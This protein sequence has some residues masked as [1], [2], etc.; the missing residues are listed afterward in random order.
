MNK[1]MPTA[2]ATVC[3]GLVLIAC[4]G[5]SGTSGERLESFTAEYLDHFWRDH[6]E[7]ATADGVH[8][9]DDRLS[10]SA[11]ADFEAEAADLRAFQTKLDAIPES[12]LGPEQKADRLWLAA[13]ME[14][15][16][17][18]LERER[19][20][21]RDPTKYI[22]FDGL[23]DLIQEDFAPAAERASNLLRRLGQ[24]PVMVSNARRNLG[25]PPRLFTETAI[26]TARAMAPFYATTVR[27]FAKA[28]PPLES[29]LNRAADEAAAAVADYAT[30]LEKE[31]LPR[32]DGDLAVG[33]QLYDF[34]LKRLHLLDDDAD[35]LLEKAQTYF[36]DAQTELEAAARDIDP[37]RTWQEITEEIRNHHP[38]RGGLLQA[39]CDEIH[40]SRE[41]VRS[42]DLVTLPEGE[43]VR[44]LHTPPSQ[45]A[46]SPFG[47]FRTPAPFSREKIGYLV[48]H[49]IEPGL[50]P[51]QEERL[52]RAHDYS[53]IQVIAPHESYPGHHL[54]ALK[55]QENPRL[56]R[57]VHQSSLFSEGWGL[58]CEELMYETGFF[59]N[60][61]ATRLTQLRLRLWRAARVILDASLHTGKMSY[62]EARRFL[63]EQVRFEESS[64]AGE[65]NIYAFRPTYAISYIVGYHEILKL[66]DECRR[67]E[68]GRFSLKDFHD[69]LLT[70]GA[71]PFRLVRQLES[72]D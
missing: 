7:Q 4:G 53:W 23:N 9:Y 26:Q 38:T 55:A 62:D 67:R 13:D 27:D 14:V 49:P 46:F 30:F 2:T 1:A 57:K 18:R 45:R 37:N 52:L 34:Y 12:G 19:D 22:P 69:R 35:S 68:G 33:R 58:Y 40:R 63:V 44:C 66:R 71:M 29:D 24:V 3:L 5:G 59:K 60:P 17:A 42:H 6:P 10:P 8:Q 65:V 56:F 47:D 36:H 48:L 39:Y 54:Q 64:T 43:E 31:L 21:A 51:D 15:R 28:V 11:A 41:H 16:L 32:S 61:K 72:Q 25:R 50:P 20:W 70:R